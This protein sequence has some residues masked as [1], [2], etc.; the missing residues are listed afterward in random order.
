LIAKP[1]TSATAGV[2]VPDG[3]YFAMGDNRDSSLDSP[4]WG[5]VL[6]EKIIG[7]LIH[8]YRMKA[9]AK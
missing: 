7:M 5:F 4:H 8:M 6:R 3:Y 9:G 1:I 2:I